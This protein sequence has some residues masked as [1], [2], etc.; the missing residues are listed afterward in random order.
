MFHAKFDIKMISMKK[1]TLFIVFMQLFFLLYSQDNVGIGTTTPHASALL[2]LQSTTKGLLIP[3]VT[4]VSVTNNTTPVQNPATGLM[5]YNTGGSL[6]SGFWYWDGT[7]WRQIGAA[8]ASCVTLNE[9]YN[10]GGAGAGRII[11][12]NAGAVEI[13]VPTGSSNTTGLSAN[14]SIGTQAN[15]SNAIYAR[16][17]QHGVA[18]FAETTL[19]TN[20]YGAIQASSIITNTNS[21][22]LPAAI[23][24]YKSGAGIGAGVYGEAIGSGSVAG[25]GVA[26]ATQNNNFGGDF[27][28]QNFVALMAETGQTG[29]QAAQIVSAGANPLQP[30]LLVYGWSQFRCS[31]QAQAHSWIFNN[32]G[33]EP[34][35]AASQSQYGLLGTSTFPIYQGYALQFNSISQKELKRNIISIDENLAEMIMRDIDGMMP[36]FYK[37]KTENDEI[38]SGQESRTRFHMHLGLILD[39]VPD[40]IQDNTFSAIDIYALATMGIVGVKHTRER[41]LRVEQRLQNVEATKSEFGIAKVNGKRVRINFKENFGGVIPVVTITPTSPISGYYIPEQDDKGFVIELIE[42]ADVV[43]NWIAIAQVPVNSEQPF[44]PDIS[45]SPEIWSQLHVDPAKKQ[46]M[47][48]YIVSRDQQI[49]SLYERPARVLKSEYIFNER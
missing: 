16:N 25:A 9:A 20:L 38:I 27:Y 18:I 6:P 3:R 49:M 32:L 24:G 1:L 15:P 34:T 37:F 22:Y 40:Y 33:G 11:T 10:C 26:G 36:S 4:L 7:Q 5:V 45:V 30:S 12:A 2:E 35:I 17:T 43:F 41:V 23:N 31:N 44:R 39:N 29:T 28:A 47:K 14:I 19:G 48:S 42:P 21:A 46:L 8:G 13:N